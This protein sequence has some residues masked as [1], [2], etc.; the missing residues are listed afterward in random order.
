MGPREE[1]PPSWAPTTVRPTTRGRTGATSAHGVAPVASRA[2]PGVRPSAA[3][4]G[5]T[6]Q[7]WLPWACLRDDRR[8]L[9]RPRARVGPQLA[10][11][12]APAAS[13]PAVCAAVRCGPG[14]PT[15][16]RVGLDRRARPAGPVPRVAGG[17]R[18]PAGAGRH[19]RDLSAAA[20]RRARCAEV[21]RPPPRAAASR[22]GGPKAGRRNRRVVKGVPAESRRVRSRRQ[23]SPR[24]T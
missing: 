24:P 19:C 11:V 8:H 23:S 13:R 10:R 22:A 9:G 7:R 4:P 21:C 6:P 5:W 17:W 3:S 20:G 16:A 14:P 12:E 2:I 18:P 1:R 15:T